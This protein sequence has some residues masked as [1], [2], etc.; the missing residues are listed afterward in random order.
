MAYAYLSTGYSNN[1]GP[2]LAAENIRMAYELRAKVSE[3]ERFYIESHYYWNG[4]GELEKAVPVLEQWQQTYPGYYSPYT[5]LGYIYRTML[6]NPEKALEQAREAMRLE[7]NSALSYDNLGVDYIGLN[8]LQEAEAVF[9]QAEERKL[10]N[11]GM[12]RSRYRLA[13]LE[14]DTA[15]M[16]QIASAAMGKPGKEEFILTTQADTE[17]WYGRLK[18]A[19]ELNRRATDSALHNSGKEPAASYQVDEALL[20]AASG[21]LKLARTDADAALKLAPSR[22]VRERAALALAQ[23]GDTAAAEKLAAGLDKNFPVDTLVQRYWLPAIRAAIALEHKDPARAV[24]Q[25]QVANAIELGDY[26]LIAVHLRG[27]AYLML[28]DGT[29]AAAE[30]QKFIDYRGRVANAEWGALARLGLGRAYV[31]QGDIP[32]AKAAY[33]D[34]LTLWKDADPD[35]P[36]LQPRATTERSWTS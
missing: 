7:P 11:D 32:R 29:H 3:R 14:G 28:H 22:D 31:L 12:P 16:A 34:F 13:F 18:D 33:R 27:Q 8:R 30:F 35:L 36:V 6:G 25:L 4:T 21:D 5:T 2:E 10:E 24:E 9:K 26:R 20:E 15:R 1:R 23:A 19:R 17:A